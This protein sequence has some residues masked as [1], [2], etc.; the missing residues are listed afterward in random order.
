MA[1]IED[2]E[3]S[4]FNYSKFTNTEMNVFLA[5]CV[6]LAEKKEEKIT[7]SLTDLKRLSG[8]ETS[9]KFPIFN[10]IMRTFN[11]VSSK[12]IKYKDA[13]GDDN[14][15]TLF[16][17][18]EI[19]PQT[20]SFEVLVNSGL[21]G[22][23][24]GMESSYTKYTLWEFVQIDNPFAK[25]MFLYIMQWR[26]TAAMKELNLK[27]LQNI[28]GFPLS[29]DD[30]RIDERVI[31][32]IKENLSPLIEGFKVSKMIRNGTTDGYSFSFK[33]ILLQTRVTE[34]QR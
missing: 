9:S 25:K 21:V 5:L 11:R 24:N 3:F 8:I 2:H 13:D 30:E 1:S 16:Y 17:N 33:P 28:L 20:G 34:E 22:I 18:Y 6:Q 12:Y 26:V 10:A 29:Y 27:K 32:P 23:L 14:V 7:I 4:K 31:T 15:G 19:H